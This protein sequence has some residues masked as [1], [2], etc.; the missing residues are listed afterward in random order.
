MPALILGPLLR[1]AGETDA[2]VWVETSAPCMVEVLGCR[3][4]TFAVAGHHFALVYVQGLEPGAARAYE[5]RLDGTVAWPPAGATQPP[6]L[7]RTR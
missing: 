7:I 3:A 5:V 6:S 4:P 2:L 1:H